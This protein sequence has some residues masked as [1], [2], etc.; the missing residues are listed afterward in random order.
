[1]MN[2][3]I[4]VD[5][6]LND[7]VTNSTIIE[8]FQFML[9]FSKKIAHADPEVWYFCGDSQEEAMNY[10]AFENGVRKIQ[11]NNLKK[12]KIVVNTGTILKLQKNCNDL[13]H[14]HPKNGHAFNM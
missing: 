7:N 12:F 10:K 6:K 3:N 2:L 13:E 14:L 4:E 11:N 1:M 5:I 9:Q 8:I